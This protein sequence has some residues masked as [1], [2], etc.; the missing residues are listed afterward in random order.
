MTTQECR[1]QKIKYVTSVHQTVQGMCPRRKTSSR[2]WSQ[3]PVSPPSTTK[4][5][6]SLALKNTWNQNFCINENLG[7]SI[8][9]VLTKTYGLI[10][11]FFDPVIV[12]PCRD[13]FN[14]YRDQYPRSTPHK[15]YQKAWID[16]NRLKI[17]TE[18]N[19]QLKSFIKK[20]RFNLRV[21]IYN[22]KYLRNKNSMNW[23]R[24][25]INI[26]HIKKDTL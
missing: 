8:D 17:R 9:L 5:W 13:N 16:L 26:N 18:F 6:F 2:S 24:V 23:E 20:W 25:D 22:Y 12:I 4:T 3:S 11:M 21:N 1:L 14:E 7:I 10:Q 19:K 15:S